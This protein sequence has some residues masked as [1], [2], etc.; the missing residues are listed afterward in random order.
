M[1]I[2]KLKSGSYRI[3]KMYKGITYTV[4]TDYKPTQKEAVQLM[5]AE[6]DKIQATKT[7]MTFEEAAE[8][9]IDMKENILSPASVRE[10]KGKIKRLSDKFNNTRISDIAS[11]DIQKEI[12]TYSKGR[13]AK[14]VSDMHG[15]I[16]A[17]MGTFCPNTIINTSLPKKSKSEPY[18][19]SEDDVKK[20]LDYSKG[21][22]FEIPL[23][24]A[25]FGLRR[26][27]IC[28]LTLDDLEGN[29][30][31]INKSK[32]MN[33]NKEWIIKTPKT[34]DS[35][36]DVLIPEELANRIREQGYIY[37]GA[38]GSI[39][40]YLTK[41]QTKLG[42]PHFSA[43]KLRHYFASV[44]HSLGIPDS[45]IMQMAGWKTDIVLRSVYRHALSDKKEEM[46][47]FASDYIKEIIL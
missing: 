14:T 38:P 36:R 17:V 7:P 6:L 19:P 33:K 25:C 1:K 47:K 11:V 23:M 32:V 3:R 26:G 40:G 22:I 27:E 30:L 24:L 12:N 41:A 21:T 2:E 42:I 5:A 28:A 45:Y 44:C 10:Y 9:Y 16:S 13:S 39:T 15:F 35:I 8:K 31:H 46:Q 37:Q 4:V 29:I 34:P 43:H 20:I 18:I